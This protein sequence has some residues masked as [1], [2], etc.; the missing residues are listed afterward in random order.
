[1]IELSLIPLSPI[2]STNILSTEEIDY[3]SYYVHAY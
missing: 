2:P 1:M 3:R